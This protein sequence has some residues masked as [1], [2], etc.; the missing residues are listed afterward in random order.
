VKNSALKNIIIILAVLFS[1]PT[2]SQEKYW[3]PD[4][5]T[6]WD[7]SYKNYMIGIN[8]SSST[9]VPGLKGLTDFDSTEMSISNY[10]DQGFAT[11]SSDNFSYILSHNQ[12]Q[13]VI[14]FS[15]TQAQDEEWTR[16]RLEFTKWF[17]D[18]RPQYEPDKLYEFSRRGF[19]ADIRNNFL[20]K[21]QIFIPQNFT[22]PEGQSGFAIRTSV[23]DIHGHEWNHGGDPIDT[24]KP[25]EFGQW[26]DFEINYPALNEKYPNSNGWFYSMHGD[27]WSPSF[28][29]VRRPIEM[30]MDTN[31]VIPVDTSHI[32]GIFFYLMPGQDVSM[33]G[34]VKIRNLVIGDGSVRYES[35]ESQEIVNKYWV[36]TEYPIWDASASRFLVSVN[37]PNTIRGNGLYGLTDFTESN[38]TA[39]NSSDDF[40][41][42]W[43]TFDDSYK[44]A[45]WGDQLS[46][47][48]DRQKGDESKW[49]TFN[50]DF[51]R[52][53]GE[54]PDETAKNMADFSRGGYIADLRDIF[55]IKGWI[56][57]PADFPISKKTKG[58]TLRADVVDV[59]GH[60][61]NSGGI[62]A[63]T[64]ASSD[65]GK[66]IEFYINYPLMAELYSS[67]TAWGYDQQ[68]DGYS[69]F[70]N[71]M[72]RPIDKGF[73][74]NVVPIDTAQITGIRFY[75]NSGEDD[76]YKGQILIRDMEVGDGSLLFNPEQF[77]LKIEDSIVHASFDGATNGAI[78]IN[79]TG[80]IK[81]YSFRWD[82]NTTNSDLVG[83]G[84]GTYRLWVMDESNTTFEKV[85][86]IKNRTEGGFSI[87]GKVV[88]SNEAVAN[89]EVI[90]YSYGS[91]SVPLL[92]QKV[93]PD[94]LFYFKS[95]PEGEY[96]LFAS[97]EGYI[98]KYFINSEKSED[99]LIFDLKG[100]AY[101]VQIELEEEESISDEEG[102]IYGRIRM[103]DE[104]FIRSSVFNS[105][106]TSFI[107]EK[108]N[109]YALA[110]GYTVYLVQNNKIIRSAIS[111]IEGNYIFEALKPDDYT[112]FIDK[113]T[114]ISKAVTIAEENLRSNDVML[115]FDLYNEYIVSYSS[116]FP[117]PVTDRNELMVFPSITSGWLTV[118]G[119]EA[120]LF[121]I[122]NLEGSKVYTSISKSVNISHL[123]KGVYIVKYTKGSDILHSKVILK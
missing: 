32:G 82:N 42:T 5:Y 116:Q 50:I 48:F 87:E 66:W 62:P 97:A 94:G 123:D 11:W 74:D 49:A 15:R 46:V 83:V 103:M 63:D 67:T 4:V 27:V 79:V 113:P 61:W 47:Y 55:L 56:K 53:I 30:E 58:F 122:F 91:V 80:G 18:L 115:N 73:Y 121:E 40:I 77:E 95:L 57:I 54:V 2:S 19:I 104:D 75:L 100:E 39:S 69:D 98:S 29:N 60:E 101:H 85:F 120:G 20:V 84:A 70:F 36:P 117:T 16:F 51:G 119:G 17:S 110:S 41:G 43:H 88:C 96:Q 23:I 107:S 6:E 8:E 99:A 3:D 92:K 28:Y 65:F 76:N 102:A 90:L 35:N 34:I 68:G 7:A 105:A 9:I 37:E 14:D 111:D 13:L 22:V 89:A 44:L 52:W 86:E 114:G 26:A 21:G 106:Q 81:P 25:D 12:N 24:I 59:H 71:N 31:H 93:S 45:S 112:V 38:I 108:G 118:V 64:I 1:L 72:P 109:E 33:H 10:N 78:Y